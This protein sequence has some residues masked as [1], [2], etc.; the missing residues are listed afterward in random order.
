ME[1]AFGTQQLLF[2]VSTIFPFV[3]NTL[4]ERH[5]NNWR[6][7]KHCTIQEQGGGFQNHNGDGEHKFHLRIPQRDHRNYDS[8]KLN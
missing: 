3:A 5:K 7:E 1:N 6:K 2:R 8:G 4:F